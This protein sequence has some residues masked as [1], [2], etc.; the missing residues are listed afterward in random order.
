MTDKTSEQFSSTKKRCTKYT[1]HC[2]TPSVHR[3]NRV[4]NEESLSVNNFTSNS[5]THLESHALTRTKN[6]KKWVNLRQQKSA[7]LRT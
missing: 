3:T 6:Y 1:E 5:R 7:A 2:T 4:R